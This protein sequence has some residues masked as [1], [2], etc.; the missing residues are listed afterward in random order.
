[1]IREVLGP[2]GLVASALPGYEPRPGQLAMAERI[3]LA[4]ERDDRLL[5]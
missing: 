2:G 5:V 3:A 4:I 1:M